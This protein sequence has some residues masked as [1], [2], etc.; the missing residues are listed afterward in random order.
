MHFLVVS[1]LVRRIKSGNES[2]FDKKYFIKATESKI[3]I[4]SSIDI[5]T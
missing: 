1:L 3:L 5:K 2:D 4:F